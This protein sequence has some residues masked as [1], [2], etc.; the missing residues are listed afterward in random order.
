LE[1]EMMKDPEFRGE[2]R[3][4]E[5]EEISYNG[6]R[7]KVK[8]VMPPFLL[9]KDHPLLHQAE[10]AL[11][12]LGESPSHVLW[13]FNT[14]GGCTATEFNIPTIGYSPGE[15]KYA[16]VPDE[17]IFIDFIS[18]SIVGNAAIAYELMKR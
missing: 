8:K 5:V 12:R 3:I 2:V 9:A 13:Y 17:R 7:E 1:E 10:T 15:E 16:H 6:Y 14:D 4:R 18:R 11:T